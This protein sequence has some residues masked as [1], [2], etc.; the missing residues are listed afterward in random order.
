M[1]LRQISG[2]QQGNVQSCSLVLVGVALARG[3]LVEPTIKIALS[4]T[5]DFLGEFIINSGE[6]IIESGRAQSR[7]EQRIPSAKSWSTASTSRRRTALISESLGSDIEGRMHERGKKAW[8]LSSR[9]GKS[10]RESGSGGGR[11]EEV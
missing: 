1:R 5:C 8:T 7:R 9:S 6:F 4:A 11:D 3:D 10:T 2:L